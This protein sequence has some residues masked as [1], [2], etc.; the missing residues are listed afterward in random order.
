MILHRYIIRR[1]V[2]PFLFSLLVITLLFLLSA[3]VTLSNAA[4]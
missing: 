4:V 3:L 2:G 1:Q